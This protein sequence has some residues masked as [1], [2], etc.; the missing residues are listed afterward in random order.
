MRPT[1][2]MSTESVA[3][4]KRLYR[5]FR[6]LDLVDSR[7]EELEK[8]RS[9]AQS[10]ASHLAAAARCECALLCAFD[11]GPGRVPRSWPAALA[12]AFILLARLAALK[13]NFRSTIFRT[14]QCNSCR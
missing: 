3:D 8:G 10:V 6:S 14:Y 13:R 9:V 7:L 4:G 11:A 1:G 12:D 2:D 5:A